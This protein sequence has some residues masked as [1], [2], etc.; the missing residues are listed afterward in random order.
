MT[1]DVILTT[2]EHGEL[3]ERPIRRAR[4]TRNTDVRALLEELARQ[5]FGPAHN[6]RRDSYLFGWVAVSRDGETLHLR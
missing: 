3:I 1:F 5:R 2:M 4:V 6:I